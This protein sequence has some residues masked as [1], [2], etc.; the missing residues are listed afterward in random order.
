MNLVL[1][2]GDII[3]KKEKDAIAKKLGEVIVERDQA[4][5]KLV[6]LDLLKKEK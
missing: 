1:T 5:G 4:A 2:N 6:S 3:L